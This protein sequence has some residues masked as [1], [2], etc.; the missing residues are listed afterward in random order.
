[1][2]SAVFLSGCNQHAD[3][4]F[5]NERGA[6]EPGYVERSLVVAGRPR[7]WHLKIPTASREG[8]PLPLLVA[9]HGGGGTGAKLNQLTGFDELAEKEGVFL[10][11]PEGI[12]KGWNDGRADM[13]TTAA[14]EEVPDVEFL[15]AV[16]DDAERTYLVDKERVFAAG[17]SNGAM[18]SNRLACELSDKIAGVALVAGAMPRSIQPT[19]APSRPVSVLVMFGTEDPLVPYAGGEVKI[20]GLRARGM[21]IGAE[22]TVAEW[23]RHDGCEGAPAEA[24]LPDT[25]P[26][27]GST[28]YVETWDRCKEGTGVAFFKI[29]GGGHTWPGG[30]Q[31]LNE[32][33]IGTT[34]RDIDARSVIWRFFETH[35]RKR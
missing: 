12:D 13:Q 35:P 15:S 11:Y 29:R 28:V 17:I 5:G 4:K 21:V 7:T 22:A 24:E 9:L 1:V 18:M 25:N 23:V 6:S 32:R 30:W 19:C 27:D 34:N 31:Y 20:R 14:R 33:W 10:A 26:T 8:R 16:I 2:A 3:T